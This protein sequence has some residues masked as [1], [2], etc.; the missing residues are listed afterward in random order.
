MKKL[1]KVKTLKFAG[2]KNYYIYK[3]V[4]K[5]SKCTKYSV[6]FTIKPSRK[7]VPLSINNFDWF[8]KGWMMGLD[9][10]GKIEKLKIK[11]VK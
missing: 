11:K 2:G 8:I 4:D 10:W 1:V 3:V 6:S 5:K 9:K 7:K